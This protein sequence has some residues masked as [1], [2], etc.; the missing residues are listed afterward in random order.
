MP[1]MSGRIFCMSWVQRSKGKKFALCQEAGVW[2]G[3]PPPRLCLLLGPSWTFTC[4][5]GHW[6][7]HY[8]GGRASI[9]PWSWPTGHAGSFGVWAGNPELSGGGGWA[10]IPPCLW[11]DWWLGLFSRPYSLL[12][13][14]QEAWVAG[15]GLRQGCIFGIP[16][17]SASFPGPSQPGS[18]ELCKP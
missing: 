17:M 18:Q 14:S 11:E 12:L 4:G 7:L 6:R 9:H 2:L 16:S 5:R 10:R 13:E 15:R 3:C 8:R 1:P